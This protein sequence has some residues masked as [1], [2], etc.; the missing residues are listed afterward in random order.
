MTTH[1]GPLILF[2]SGETARH[3]RQ[4]QEEVLRQWSAPVKVAILVTPSG[5]QPNADFVVEKLRS[6]VERS[7]QNYK[8]QITLI[9]ANR[10]GGP[11]DPDDP[12]VY[13]PLRDADYILA[14]PGSPTYTARQL[15]G[16]GTWDLIR[17]RWSEGAA[18][19]FSSAA[20]LA[21]SAHVLPVYE[22]YKA[23]D[24]LHW[25]PGLDLLAHAGLELAIMPHWNNAEGGANL[26]TSRC[27][28]GVERFA[29]LRGLLPPSA[30]ILGIEEHTSCI[31]DVNRN[32]LAVRGQ[33]RLTI[34]RDGVEQTHDQGAELDLAL[35][36]EAVREPHP[37][38]A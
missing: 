14:G 3:G 21:L 2:G 18:L 27:F 6:F 36:G 30:T 20:A 33:G 7:L 23:G 1:H 22:I 24:D 10:K 35:L 17:T 11:G 13:A 16:T 4:V 26:D 25:Q 9:Q 28:M 19:A 8:P 34:I 31:I 15:A 12:D 5:F 38:L 32:T 29:R 37:A